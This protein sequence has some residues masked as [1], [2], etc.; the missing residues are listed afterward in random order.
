MHYAE[1]AGITGHVMVLCM[2]LM[3]AT[4]HVRVRN[5]SYETFWYC[6]HLSIPFLLG[7]YTHATGC[8]I[9]DTVDPVSPFAGNEFWSHCLGSEGWRWE[10]CAGGLYLAERVYRVVRSRRAAKIVG[11]IQHPSG[12][13]HLVYEAWLNESRDLGDPR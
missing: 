12:K 8:F 2:L 1:A 13:D 10:L 6:H 9:R 11:V 5:Q 4:A 3:Y 7:L